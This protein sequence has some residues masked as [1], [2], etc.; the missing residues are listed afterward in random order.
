MKTELDLK[1]DATMAALTGEGGPLAL[2]SIERFG[3]TL[4]VIAGA[5]P[6]LPAYF[7]HYSQ[8]H[9]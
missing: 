1:M 6:S 4:P 5:P 9:N 2:G 3:Q 7:A 8:Q